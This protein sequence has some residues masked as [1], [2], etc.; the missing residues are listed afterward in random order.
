MLEYSCSHCQLP[1]PAAALNAIPRSVLHDA[2]AAAIRCCQEELGELERRRLQDAVSAAIVASPLLR[3][4]A[5]MCPDLFSRKFCGSVIPQEE[6]WWWCTHL[7]RCLS[8][9]VEAATTW[10][11]V[12]Q[13]IG[14]SDFDDASTAFYRKHFPAVGCAGVAV[15]QGG[16]GIVCSFAARCYQSAGGRRPLTHQCAESAVVVCGRQQRSCRSVDPVLL[17]GPRVF[18]S[19]SFRPP[20]E[21]PRCSRV[22]AAGYVASRAR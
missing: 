10:L 17:Q 5:I 18:G 22:G 13:R 14:V 9:S 12:C 4:E 11:A 7:W 20:R 6:V 16:E 21:P 2:L 8:D 15:R 1:L 3:T 19:V